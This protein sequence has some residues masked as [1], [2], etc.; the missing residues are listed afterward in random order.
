[1]LIKFKNHF[2]KPNLNSN[3]IQNV[4]CEILINTIPGNTI[5]NIA[6]SVNGTVKVNA[7]GG[8]GSF[9]WNSGGASRGFTNGSGIL[10][11]I[12]VT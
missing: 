9:I 3:L 4:Y 12:Y 10:Y 1:V 8:G 7:G 2:F 11:D 6:F 5:S